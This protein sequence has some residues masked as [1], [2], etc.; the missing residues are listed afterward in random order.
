[1]NDQPLNGIEVATLEQM[2]HGAGESRWETN[3]LRERIISKAVAARSHD[4]RDLRFG[5]TLA[6]SA[7][8]LLLALTVWKHSPLIG[9]APAMIGVSPT[10]IHWTAIEN[11][12]DEE[13]QVT[14]ASRSEN[15]EWKHVTH[16]SHR[17]E[18]IA[19]LLSRCF[20]T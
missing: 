4:H 9:V 13:T 6:M 2:I 11:A 18:Q 8:S 15:R 5:H 7:M 3:G 1:M 12:S 20:G 16:T 10:V 17:Q 19:R 14:S